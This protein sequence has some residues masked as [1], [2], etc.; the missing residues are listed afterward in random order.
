MTRRPPRST[1][2]PYTTLFRSL[3]RGDG[4]SVLAR[5]DRAP[6]MVQRRPG[7]VIPVQHA[8]GCG[9]LTST[10]VEQEGHRAERDSRLGGV[11][12][13]S[14]ELRSRACI[15]HRGAVETAAS[16]V[17]PD[18]A[19]AL[20]R[21]VIELF[22]PFH[23]EVVEERAHRPRA[24]CVWSTVEVPRAP[25]VEPP[26]PHQTVEKAPGRRRHARAFERH[27]GS[28]CDRTPRVL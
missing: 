6:R 19:L 10:G 9:L 22:S 13:P 1:L 23:A 18:H 24:R 21:G 4:L 17:E 3:S 12:D 11:R 2:F 7:E 8:Q 20:D 16:L 27:A 26:G 25:N 14:H 15:G 28:W 5:E